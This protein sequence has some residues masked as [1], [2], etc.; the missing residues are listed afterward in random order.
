M[1]AFCYVLDEKLA[2]KFGVSWPEFFSS[3]AFPT[4]NI[5][6]TVWLSLLLFRATAVSGNRAPD[7]APVIT[8]RDW[9]VNGTPTRTT[10][11]CMC[12]WSNREACVGPSAAPTQCNYEYGLSWH[13]YTCEDCHCAPKP[14]ESKDNQL[15]SHMVRGTHAVE[16]HPDST[17][18]R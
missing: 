11:E 6:Y 15:R 13:H 1:Q 10:G 3:A 4:M 12:R 8:R 5:P 9:C 2:R 16:V 18:A 17:M 14:Y 7:T